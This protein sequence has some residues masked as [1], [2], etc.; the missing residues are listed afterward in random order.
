MRSEGRDRVALVIVALLLLVAT[1]LSAC[2]DDPYRS[3]VRDLLREL[4][5]AV[6]EV[7]TLMSG[8]SAAQGT[9]ADAQ[10]AYRENLERAMTRMSAAIE[11]ASQGLGAL[12]PP[13][14][15]ARLFQES[16]LAGLQDYQDGIAQLSEAFGYAVSASDVLVRVTAMQGEGGAWARFEQVTS[17][18]INQQNV[19]E[20]AAALE[21]AKPELAAILQSWQAI[22]PPEQAKAE[23]GAVATDLGNIDTT[24]GTMV[25]LARAAVESDAGDAMYQLTLHWELAMD[26]WA[27]MLED[28]DAWFNKTGG[29]ADSITNRLNGIQTELDRLAD[30]L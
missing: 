21:T 13:D 1:T 14:A 22:T 8:D 27:T 9:G 11:R 17:T 20:L 4:D 15:E 7:E 28:M 12:T 18:G 19:T 25:G 10:A 16:Y 29:T 2:G 24:V 26:Q 30:T 6:S 23:H 5:T 3:A